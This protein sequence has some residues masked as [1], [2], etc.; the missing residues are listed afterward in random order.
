MNQYNLKGIYNE[1]WTAL[2]KAVVDRKSSFHTFSLATVNNGIADNRTVV[3]RGCNKKMMTLTFNTNNSSDKI[4][5]ISKNN[6]V[7]AL[8]YDKDEKIQ[9]RFI[10][11]AT[12]NNNNK[13]CQDKWENMSKQS[14]ACYFQTVNP[15]RTIEHPSI[16]K[17]K[18]NEEMSENFTIVDISISSIDWLY[19]SATGHSRAKYTKENG[20]EGEWIAP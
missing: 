3:L 12:I 6:S 17:S 10:G 19:L 1:L 8:F 13:Y 7:S 18:Y 14:R 2:E 4:S 15:G 5:H 16:V 11:N 20:Y 9:I